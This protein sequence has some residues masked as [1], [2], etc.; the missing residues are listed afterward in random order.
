MR[1]WQICWKK[2]IQSICSVSLGPYIPTFLA[3]TIQNW[4]MF[5]SAC[6]KLP[7]TERC[8]ASYPGAVK[9][10]QPVFFQ[11]SSCGPWCFFVSYILNGL[12][13]PTKRCLDSAKTVGGNPN[14][15]D[16]AGQCRAGS[17]VSLGAMRGQQTSAECG[18]RS[19]GCFFLQR[20]PCSLPILTSID[21]G[22]TMER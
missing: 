1:P 2:I 19:W 13:C 3:H 21:L 9:L 10:E 11:L 20:F 15:W 16:P 4:C 6:W 8:A 18:G 14:R 5:H 17:G 22:Y 7:G 12:R